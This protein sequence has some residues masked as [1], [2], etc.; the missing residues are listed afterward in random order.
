VIVGIITG[1][2]GWINQSYLKEQWKILQEG[3]AV[4]GR[5]KR[6]AKAAREGKT[7]G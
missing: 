7:S 3:A 1:L 5:G 2:I 6:Q 4:H